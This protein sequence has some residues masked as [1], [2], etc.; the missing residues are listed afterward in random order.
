MESTSLL[1]LLLPNSLQKRVELLETTLF[2]RC[3]AAML[4]GS[5][6]SMLEVD[7]GAGIGCE[8][9]KGAG[10]LRLRVGKTKYSRDGGCM[11]AGTSSPLLCLSP[12]GCRLNNNRSTHSSLNK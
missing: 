2:V 6:T 12:A 3:T 10:A 11:T 7:A 4:H 9:D 8:L 1:F 5:Y